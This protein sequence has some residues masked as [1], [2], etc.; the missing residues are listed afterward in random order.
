MLVL[1]GRVFH[2]GRIEPLDVGIEGGKIAAMKKVLRSR[3]IVDYG[4]RIILPGV[5]D[6]HVHMREPGLTEKEDFA[7]GTRSAALGG[8]TTVLDMPNTVPPVSTRQALLAKQKTVSGRSTIDY[9]LYAGPLS[10][11]SVDGL[12]SADAFK[13]YMAPSTGDLR[14][15]ETTLSEIVGSPKLEGRFLSVHAEDPRLFK[16]PQARGL[17]GHSVGRPIAAEVRA[18]ETVAK[19]P[20]KAQAHVAHVTCV[21]AL[22]AVVPGITTE[23]APHHLLLDYR[24]SVGGLGKV[25][26]PLRSP[27]D[28]SELWDA[29]ASGRVDIVASDHAPHT[30]DEKTE[31]AFDDVPAGMPGVATALP[32]LLRRVHAQ[33]LTLER[34]VSAMATRPAQLLGLAKG[35]VEVGRNAD[36]IVV[37]P[38]RAEMITARRVRY[39]CGWTAFEGFEGVFP[40]AVYVR[41]E[42]IVEDGEV[43]AEGVGRPIQSAGKV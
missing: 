20:S 25:N 8:V 40:E 43:I 31:G 6:L 38:R 24:S 41:G 4:D 29:F 3:E 19:L 17:E 35:A 5:I 21:E 14:I 1:R 27:R 30:L 37:D 33:D 13:L 32:L 36:L 26:P 9:G 28:R 18:I 2:G 11:S 23:V 15:S 7:S 39:K 34:L 22:Q 42:R 10:A 16:K 12:V